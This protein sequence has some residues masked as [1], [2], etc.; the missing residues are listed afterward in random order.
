MNYSLKKGLY[1]GLKFVLVGLVAVV[2]VVGLSDV[3]IWDLIVE[4]VKPIA[5]TLTIG[6]ALTMALNFIKVKFGKKKV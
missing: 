5:G 3:V 2:A 4:Y 6:T 1:K